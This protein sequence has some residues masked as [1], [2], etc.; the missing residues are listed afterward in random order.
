MGE[1]LT[2]K[3]LELI[4]KAFTGVTLF[5]LDKLLN[6]LAKAVPEFK[7]ELA[8]QD[9]TVIM[10][11]RDNSQ[12]RLLYFRGGEVT[13][14]NGVHDAEV[15]MIFES[16]T[17]ARRVMSGQML[18]KTSEFVA[19][20]KNGSLILNG[21][22]E[23]AMWFS[24]LLLKVFLFDVLYLGNYGT[25]MPNGETRL[26]SG[27]NGGPLFVYV[28]DGKIVRMT[29][30][31]FDADDAEPWTIT[32]RGKKFTPPKRT[33]ITPYAV[34]WK[35]QIYSPDRLLY[36][37]KR[38]DFDPNG[39]RNPQN[40]GISGYERISWD[41][42][43]DIVSSEIM[44]VRQTYGPGAVFHAEGSHH[45]W[46]NI[47]YYISASKRFFNCIGATGI[48]ANPDS[49]EGFAWG[50][51]HH[52]GGSARRGAT[53]FYSCVEDCMKNAE[54]IVFWSADPESTSGVYGG[55]EGTI[56]RE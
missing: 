39:E 15:E 56:R 16:N 28:K 19:A 40:R 37:M 12:G 25:L 18:G 48:L 42:A 47:G 20:A 8:K 44:R 22:D 32:A 11:L 51:M 27:T 6:T 41:E 17:V 31:D 49:W 43:L 7:K 3:A 13:G 52:Y 26:V 21:P 38:V 46:G 5:T 30:I 50:A 14:K 53:E 54:M 33:T 45:T 36:P 9:M 1:K 10:K 23:K 35:S 55:Q 24:S 2:V 29:P 34:G 4:D